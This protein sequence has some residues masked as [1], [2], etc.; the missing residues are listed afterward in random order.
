MS[1]Q[2]HKRQADSGKV[3]AIAYKGEQTSQCQCNRAKG[4]LTAEKSMQSRVKANRPRNVNAIETMRADQLNIS[5]MHASG[6]RIWRF[7]N[8]LRLGELAD[9]YISMWRVC[10]CSYAEKQADTSNVKT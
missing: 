10:Q 2:S 7:V 1:M 8:A 9:K 6:R 5:S 4:K 3:N